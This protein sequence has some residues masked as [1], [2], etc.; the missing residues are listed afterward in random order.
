MLEGDADVHQV[1]VL[2]DLCRTIGVGAGRDEHG[3]LG[4]APL[5]GVALEFSETACRMAGSLTTTK[6]QHCRLAQEGARRAASSTACGFSSSTGLSSNLRMLRRSSKIFMTMG[7][8][9]PDAY[10]DEFRN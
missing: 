7:G 2:V 1:V 8:P 3:R 10:Q 4:H 9:L 5:A 6:L